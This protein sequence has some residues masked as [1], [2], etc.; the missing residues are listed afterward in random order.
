MNRYLARTLVILVVAALP[1]VGLASLADAAPIN[2]N[3]VDKATLMKDCNGKGSYVEDPS[4]TLGTCISKAPQGPIVTCDYTKKGKNCF[5]WGLPPKARRVVEILL[6]LLRSASGQP[7][8]GGNPGG[9]GS[10][11]T[12]GTQPTSKTTQPVPPSTTTTTKPN[13]IQ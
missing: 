5:S 2:Q 12:P 13:V 7:T 1:V 11:N 9:S 3:N 4:G 10:T 8:T 6:S